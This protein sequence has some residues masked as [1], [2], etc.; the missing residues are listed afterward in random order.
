MPRSTRT[1]PGLV[2]PIAILLAWDRDPRREAAPPGHQVDRELTSRTP[3]AAAPPRP[4]RSSPR[5]QGLPSG[6]SRTRTGGL[7]GAIVPQ[8]V[9][10]F[11]EFPRGLAR[12]DIPRAKL[13]RGIDTPRVMFSGWWMLRRT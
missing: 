9:R 12:G 13:P 7:L 5:L 1:R 3:P 2:D 10:N 11:R 8:I 4:R 6:A